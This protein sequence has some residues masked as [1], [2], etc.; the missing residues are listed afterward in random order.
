M[1]YTLLREKCPDDD[2]KIR[3]S[4]ALGSRVSRIF[5]VTSLLVPPPVC[6]DHGQTPEVEDEDAPKGDGD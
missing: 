4:G 2:C 5:G 6:V 3:Q 1:S